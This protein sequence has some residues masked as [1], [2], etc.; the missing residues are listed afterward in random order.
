[1]R[2]NSIQSGPSV[3]MM[4]FPDDPL[5]QMALTCQK[6]ETYKA[7]FKWTGTIYGNIFYVLE[8]EEHKGEWA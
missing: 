4:V 7:G 6:Y 8:I 5:Y 1:M 2:D 3:W